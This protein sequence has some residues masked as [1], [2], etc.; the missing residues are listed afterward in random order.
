M[1]EM[2]QNFQELFG[3]FSDEKSRDCEIGKGLLGGSHQDLN[4]D[5][6]AHKIAIV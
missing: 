1:K 6:E 3:T 4:D 2:T 5:F